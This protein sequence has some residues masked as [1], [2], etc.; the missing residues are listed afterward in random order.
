MKLIQLPGTTYAV[1]PAWVTCVEDRSDAVNYKKEPWPHV[2]VR[3]CLGVQQMEARL[4][5]VS[6]AEV[7]DLFN[8]EM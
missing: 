3:W 2:M 8:K 1:N 6:F 5:G 7:V 4:V